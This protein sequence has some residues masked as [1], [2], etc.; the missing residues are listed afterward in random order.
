MRLALVLLFFPVFSIAFAATPPAAGEPQPKVRDAVQDRFVPVPFETQAVA[1]LFGERMRINLEKRLLEVDEEALLAGF[2]KQPGVQEWIGEHIGK[3]LDAAANTWRLT[4]NFR[5]KAQMDR[6]A[7]ALIACQKADGYLGTYTDD[8]RWTS[9]D[10]WVHKY[11]LLGLLAWYRVTG[12][13]RALTASRRIGDL[14]IAT[15]QTGK[16]DIIVS[17]EHV[18]M[19]ATSV[20]EPVCLLYRYTGDPRYLSF[21]RFIV[22]K[23]WEQPNGPHIISSLLTTGSV[24]KTA[25]AEAYE[26]M[27]DLVGLCELYRLIGEPR[28]LQAALA[29]QKDIVTHRRYL[30]GTTSSHE[31]FRDD[32]DLPAEQKDEVGEGCAT[33]TWLQLNLQLLR[34]TGEAKYAQELERTAFNQLLAAQDPATGNICYFTP[35]DGRKQPTTDINCCRSSEPRGISLIPQ[36][37]WGSLRAASGSEEVALEILAPG[38]ALIDGVLVSTR[39]DYPFKGQALVSLIP[40]KPHNFTLAIRVPEWATSFHVIGPDGKTADGKP[41]EYLRL[42]RDWK[43]GD[44]VE[45]KVDL[46]VRFTPGGKSYPSRYAVERGPLVLALDKGAS[47]DVPDIAAASLKSVPETLKEERA[48]LYTLP[49]VLTESGVQRDIQ[50]HLVPFA[51]AREYLIWLPAAAAKQ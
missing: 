27:S 33:V 44:T 49:G 41:G 16:R 22:D 42:T 12:D 39:T 1:G 2:R 34:L 4:H 17:S 37:L 20:L 31:H 30:T 5:L 36:L 8:K 24:F 13:E 3:Y 7:K 40:D 21:A 18:G 45:I 28:Y 25:N 35:M 29:A 9:W 51:D 43:R 50:L 11:D 10:V 47:Y 19:A 38:E 6:M 26:M 14:L 32:F 48:G 15:F 23:A 46:A